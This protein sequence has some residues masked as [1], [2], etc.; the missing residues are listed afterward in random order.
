MSQGSNQSR[1]E[2]E[3]KTKTG[4]KVGPV[5]HTIDVPIHVIRISR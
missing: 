1:G 5:D 3:M 4:I 2:E